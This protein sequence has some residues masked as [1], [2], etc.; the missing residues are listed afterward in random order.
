MGCHTGSGLI[1]G[2]PMKIGLSA[3]LLCM[4]FLGSSFAQEYREDAERYSKIVG[5][6]KENP[7]LSAA[8]PLNAWL[9]KRFVF[10][11][12]P[13]KAP[14]GPPYGHFQTGGRLFTYPEYEDYVGKMVKAVQVRQVH[15]RWEVKFE[16]SGSREMISATTWS[17]GIS[18][19]A[20]L[21][22]IR[23]ARERWM[24]KTLWLK[25]GKMRLY[26]DAVGKNGW[27]QVGPGAPL[28]VVNVIPGNDHNTP[29]RFILKTY[30]GQ[31]G[32]VD[33]AWSRTNVYP[34]AWQY[35]EKFSTVFQTH[36]PS[37]TVGVLASGS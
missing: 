32:Y 27:I 16:V 15:D 6:Q 30:T 13:T 23:E 19:I 9:G 33:V 3:V 5:T 4:S 36:D 18:G 17:G 26:H 1:G 11:P 37:K 2:R 22:D 28:K 21:K 12:K 25:K 29:V 20:P 35:C 34:A 14:L 10:L 24:G 31:S 8:C 7:V